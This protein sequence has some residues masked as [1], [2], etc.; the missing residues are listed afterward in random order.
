MFQF[1]IP[2]SSLVLALVAVLFGVVFAFVVHLEHRKEMAL[3]ESGQYPV[4]ADSRAWALAG[5]LLA[6]AVGVGQVVVGL[7]NEGVLGPGVTLALV[8]IAGL[9]HY[10]RKRRQEGHEGGESRDDGT[11]TGDSPG[12]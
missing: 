7:A 11:R 10:H 2:E 1:A 12:A 3:I 5:G 8:G 4:D 9:V 6:L